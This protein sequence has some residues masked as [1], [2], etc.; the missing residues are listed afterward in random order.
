[1]ETFLNINM[2]EHEQKISKQYLHCKSTVY[3]NMI[4][5]TL[6][7]NMTINYSS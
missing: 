4:V 2:N 1:M 6:H 5:F 7:K 3:I